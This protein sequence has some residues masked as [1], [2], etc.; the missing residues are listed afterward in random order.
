MHL[1]EALKGVCACMREC[2]F[3]KFK[4]VT[5][6]SSIAFRIGLMLTLILLLF[7]ML[8]KDLRTFRGLDSILQ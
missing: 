7:R 2:M 4:I 5:K 6:I 1:K 8:R 3:Q